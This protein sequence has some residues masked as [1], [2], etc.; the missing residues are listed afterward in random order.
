MFLVHKV[1]ILEL[2]VSSGLPAAMFKFTYEVSLVSLPEEYNTITTTT[3][4]QFSWCRAAKNQ[5]TKQTNL[6]GS[7]HTLINS[8]ALISGIPDPI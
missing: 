4:V 3:L 1:S 6:Q 8:W 7:F 2:Q 5:N